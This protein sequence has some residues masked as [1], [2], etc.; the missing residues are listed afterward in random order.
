MIKSG[1]FYP[2][3]RKCI[4]CLRWTY[5]SDTQLRVIFSLFFIYISFSSIK[6]KGN[7]NNSLL[8]IACNLAVAFCEWELN[9]NLLQMTLVIFGFYWLDFCSV[10]VNVEAWFI[11]Y[12][13]LLSII[14]LPRQ[15]DCQEVCRLSDLSW[16]PP[17]SFVFKQIGIWPDQ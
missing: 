5:L 14:N 12:L 17:I 4:C 8:S 1:F 9:R 11:N 3:Y 7:W 13:Q 16:N 10:G 6:I 2:F 15:L